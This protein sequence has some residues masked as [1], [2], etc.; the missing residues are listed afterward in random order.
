[1]TF[2]SALPWLTVIVVFAGMTFLI[3]RFIGAGV[4]IIMLALGQKPPAPAVP[5]PA[6]PVPAP[7]TPSVAPPTITL[8]LAKALAPLLAGPAKQTPPIPTPQISAPIIPTATGPFAGAPPW[9][10]LGLRDIGFHETGNNRGIETFIAQA[11]AG[12]LGDPW[13]AIWANAKL[14]QGG[15][16]GSHSPSS[17][18]F[19]GHPD[20]V[21]LPEPALGAIVVY[22]RDSPN[23]GVGHVGFYVDETATAVRTLGGN[24]GDMVQ[25][26]ALPKSAPNFGLRGYWWPKSVAMP[27]IGAIPT[28]LGSL[29]HVVVPPADHLAA[30]SISGRMSV[31]GGPSDTGV[32]ADEGLALV[33]PAELA[34]FDGFFLPE[35]PPGTTGLARRLD[36]AS[37]YIACRW[38]YKATS[39][40]FLQGTTV[41][42][43]AHG[44]TLQAR[45]VDWGP[46]ARTGRIADL[47]PGLA[48]ALGLKTDDV[49]EV[50]IPSPTPHVT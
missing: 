11:H 9:F 34:K 3:L 29:A 45:P 39:R 14:E 42:V 20:F 19:I 41:A 31:F 18:S 4:Q 25:I 6:A 38:D 15:V 7:P 5:I 43:T 32:A 10:V 48:G 47:S 35:Q 26:E 37:H 22:W 28:P 12:A 33:E 50:V 16:P 17:Q 44:K 46:N 40:A 24:E 30:G 2:D 1:M 49:C 8:D 21:K 27:R 13:C 23:S 36:P